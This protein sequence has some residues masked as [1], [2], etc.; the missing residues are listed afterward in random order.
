M[1]AKEKIRDLE[2]KLKLCVRADQVF[3]IFKKFKYKLYTFRPAESLILEYEYWHKLSDGLIKKRDRKYRAGIDK[4][5]EWFCNEYQDYAIFR[6]ECD[7]VDIFS[8]RTGPSWR[9]DSLA[10]K[11][12][13]S[14]LK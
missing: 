11:I 10:Y 4:Y 1:N 6:S 9:D 5:A 13:E 3:L 12:Y 8:V 7:A 2:S 14:I